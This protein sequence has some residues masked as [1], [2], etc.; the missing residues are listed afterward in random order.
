MPINLTYPPFFVQTVHPS[1][2]E[3]PQRMV[4]RV[5]NYNWQCAECKC[6]IKCRSSQQPGKMLYCEQCDRGYHIY[7]LGVKQVPDGKSK[8]VIQILEINI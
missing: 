6:C 1:C 3:M 4:A 8:K 5:R 7:C 2:I